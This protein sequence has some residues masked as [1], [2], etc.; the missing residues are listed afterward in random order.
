MK[1]AVIT[2]CSHFFHAGCLKKWLYVQ[3][4]CPLCHCHLKNSSQ[5]PGLGADLVPQPA[6]GVEQHALQGGT[7]APG[8]ELP[9]G[10]GYKASKIYV[11][12]FDFNQKQNFPF[13]AACQYFLMQPALQNFI[14]CKI[15]L[16]YK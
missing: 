16:S 5:L 10:P 7:E 1:S 4:T 8:Q 6:A 9:Q 11:Q 2:P 13:V 14:P 12:C 15:I 3:E